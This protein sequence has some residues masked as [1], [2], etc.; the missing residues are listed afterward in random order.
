MGMNV[1]FWSYLLRRNTTRRITKTATTTVIIT[2]AMI[3]SRG[4]PL[5]GLSEV[6]GS[7]G[8]VTLTAAKG[9]YGFK[10]DSI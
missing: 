9:N 7:V 8:P 5:F 6:V 10:C 4:V 1:Q 2:G 3:S